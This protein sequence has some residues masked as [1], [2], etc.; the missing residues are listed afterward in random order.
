MK[1]ILIDPEIAL[2]V[3]EKVRKGICLT[4]GC[5][6]GKNGRRGLCDRDYQ[7]Y[8]RTKISLPRRQQQEFEV[9]LIRK[10]QILARQQIRQLRNP[11]PFLLEP[12]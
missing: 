9:R 12:A 6:I 4:C 11:N 5:C 8:Y 3:L 1:T 10:G 7:I 2:I